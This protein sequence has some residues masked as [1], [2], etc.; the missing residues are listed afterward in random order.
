VYKIAGAY[1]TYAFFEWALIVFDVMFDALA[2]VEFKALD[3]SI[4]PAKSDEQRD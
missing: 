4:L 1:T 3:L 2:M